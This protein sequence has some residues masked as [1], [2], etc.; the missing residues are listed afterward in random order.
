M[1]I[2]NIYD[3]LTVLSDTI[4]DM[5]SVMRNKDAKYQEFADFQFIILVS[6]I[7]T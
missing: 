7:R 4:N 2:I 3:I 1:D 5:H 6:T